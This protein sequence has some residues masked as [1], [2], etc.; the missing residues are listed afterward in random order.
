MKNLKGK[1]FIKYNVTEIINFDITDEDMKNIINKK[2]FNI[3]FFHETSL[4]DK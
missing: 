3:I 2:L 4:N 1:F